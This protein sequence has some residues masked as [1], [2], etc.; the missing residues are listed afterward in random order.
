LAHLRLEDLD[1]LELSSPLDLEALELGQ[2][3]VELE[4]G[5]PAKGGRGW[6]EK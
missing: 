5:V 1:E 2:I 6:E 3:S 4:H